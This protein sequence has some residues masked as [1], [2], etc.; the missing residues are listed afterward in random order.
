MLFLLPLPWALVY[1][2]SGR[3]PARPSLYVLAALAAIAGGLCL[4]GLIAGL[5]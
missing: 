5:L 1:L 2:Y 4:A 3:S